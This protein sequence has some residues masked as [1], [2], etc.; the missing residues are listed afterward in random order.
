[1]AAALLLLA[2]VPSQVLAWNVRSFSAADESLMVTLTNQRRA[3]SGLPRLTVDP[4]LQSVARSRSKDMGDRGY[5]SHRIPPDGHRVF[6]ELRARGYCAESA[7]ENFAWNTYP[8]D[9]AT[10]T[11]QRQ[12]ESSAAHLKAI[13][14]AAYTRIGVGAYKAADG[15]HVWTILFADPCG[16]SAKAPAASTPRPRPRASPEPARTS[17][18][19]PT[20]TSLPPIVEV[21]IAAEPGVDVSITDSTLAEPQPAGAVMSEADDG[22]TWTTVAGA[23]LGVVMETVRALLIMLLRALGPVP[24]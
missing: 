4:T 24:T 9:S 23:W 7:A 6:D 10:R 1:V 21:P 11:A 20:P 3:A 12:L 17:P 22:D 16:A 8:D 14:G 2:S 19:A 13:L 5:F 15:K 18:P